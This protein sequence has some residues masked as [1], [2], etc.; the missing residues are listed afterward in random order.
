MMQTQKVALVT[1]SSS[2]MGLEQ[3]FYSQEVDFM[4]VLLC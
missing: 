4:L 1:G 3:Q 2:G